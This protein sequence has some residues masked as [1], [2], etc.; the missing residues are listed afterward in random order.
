MRWVFDAEEAG[1]LPP[2]V[3]REFEEYLKYGRL[4][5]G[6]LRVRC[7]LALCPDP[8]TFIGLIMLN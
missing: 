8:Y 2:S 4:E 1:A 7:D 6:L 3:V 5:H